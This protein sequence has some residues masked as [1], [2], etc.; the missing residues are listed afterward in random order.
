MT[1]ITVTP[2]MVRVFFLLIIGKSFFASWGAKML[3]K[4]AF[5]GTSSRWYLAAVLIFSRLTSSCVADG[6]QSSVLII[7]R[8]ACVFKAEV[9]K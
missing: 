2:L 3:I 5:E 9:P 7:S 1:A 6:L 4:S 8:R